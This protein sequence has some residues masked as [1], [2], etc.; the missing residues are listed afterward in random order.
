M[1]KIL[2]LIFITVITTGQVFSQDNT[3]RKRD[4]NRFEGIKQ[5][6]VEKVARNK[7][8][9]LSAIVS[10]NQSSS[11]IEMDTVKLGF[12]LNDRER[13]T[14]TICEW[15]K[16][17][18][19]VPVRHLWN[20]GFNEFAW[21]GKILQKNQIHTFDLFGL[22]KVD[23]PGVRKI[24]PIVVYTKP[25]PILVRHYDFVIIPF[26]TLDLEYKIFDLVSRQL[27]A[28]GNK[29]DCAKDQPIII[30]WNC[31]DNQGKSLKE[32]MVQLQIKGTY[33]TPLGDSHNLRTSFKFL[34]KPL[35]SQKIGTISFKR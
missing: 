27:L 25:G 32:T 20:K 2:V 23:K 31:T 26:R 5:T 3:Y 21:P 1:K 35:L 13:V 19:M 6:R 33:F 10:S 30:P 24:C 12:Y 22:A 15:G 9:L 11:I 4:G 7:I 28:K 14:I 34:H 29:I 17:Y 16:N 8:T 18:F